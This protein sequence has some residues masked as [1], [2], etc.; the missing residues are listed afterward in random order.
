MKMKRSLYSISHWETNLFS[1]FSSAL[2]SLLV[3][4]STSLQN[5]WGYRLEKQALRFAQ[6]R[7]ARDEDAQGQSRGNQSEH[8]PGAEGGQ[9]QA[10]DGRAKGFAAVG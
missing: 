9:E 10:A 4:Y 1:G 8:H 2:A 6:G 3:S 7:E 5:L